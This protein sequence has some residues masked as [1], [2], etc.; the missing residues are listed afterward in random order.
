MDFEYVWSLIIAFYE[1]GQLSLRK[2]LRSCMVL[3]AVGVIKRCFLLSGM[4]CR[5]SD[6]YAMLLFMTSCNFF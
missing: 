4:F 5:G 1:S 3:C 2:L 6:V